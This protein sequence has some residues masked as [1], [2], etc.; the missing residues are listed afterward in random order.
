MHA[1]SRADT[2]A[3]T[4]ADTYADTSPHYQDITRSGKGQQQVDVVAGYSSAK[5]Q[6][7]LSEINDKL[8]E[9]K[10]IKLTRALQQL[11]D[12]WHDMSASSDEI[13]A[14]LH[15]EQSSWD[16]SGGTMSAL[17]RIT[18]TWAANRHERQPLPDPVACVGL[19][20]DVECHKGW[21]TKLGSD[22]PVQ[23]C[24]QRKAAS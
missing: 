6:A 17:E 13:I 1:G 15:S 7:I 9:H 8:P 3:D 20:A 16:G 19:A 11:F 10:Q 12:L 18:D 22:E 14:Q 5:Q 23:P 24:P 4:Y 2:H 21:H